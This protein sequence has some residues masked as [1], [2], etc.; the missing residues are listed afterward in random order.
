MK[1]FSLIMTIILSSFFLI[2]CQSQRA[3]TQ[4]SDPSKDLALI[5]GMESVDKWKQFQQIRTQD[6][7]STIQELDKLLGKPS[8]TKKENKQTILT[9]KL[10]KHLEIHIHLNK[11]QVREKE[12]VF[13][14]T[15]G[16]CMLFPSIEDG[17]PIPEAFEKTGQA[18]AI[19]EK[20]GQIITSWYMAGKFHYLRLENGKVYQIAEP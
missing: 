5:P 13:E 6:K 3:S 9:W 1:R 15:R 14:H 10:A 2:S 12:L 20:Q 17:T 18:Y 19:R 11:D 4:A 16:T 7:P 8:Q